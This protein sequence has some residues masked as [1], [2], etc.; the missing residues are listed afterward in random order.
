[1]IILF[2]VN[3]LFYGSPN[4]ARRSLYDTSSSLRFFFDSL[5]V[6][7][8]VINELEETSRKALF[9][10]EVPIRLRQ[11][12]SYQGKP[13]SGSLPPPGFSCVK[14][15]CD[16]AKFSLVQEL[17]RPPRLVLP[18][19][20]HFSLPVS[21]PRAW[22]CQPCAEFFNAQTKLLTWPP[23]LFDPLFLHLSNLKSLPFIK[24]AR[25]FYGPPDVIPFFDIP[26]LS[27]TNLF[28]ELIW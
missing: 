6:P 17:N 27:R 22:V 18:F 19:S 28:L 10:F 23:D 8:K 2:L 11:F 3:V 4:T 24:V 16:G 25:F 26:L 14:H 20:S 7:L 9:R 13:L 1:M 5:T 21:N 15:S 12:L